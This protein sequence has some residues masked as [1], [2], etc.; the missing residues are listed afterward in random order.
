MTGELRVRADR[1]A[2]DEPDRGLPRL[3]EPSPW[4]LFF[5][6]EA[7]PWAT[8]V[9]LE[10]LLGI[11][12]EVDG[13]PHYLDIWATSQD[14]EKAAFERFIHLVIERLDAHPEMHV[15]HYGGYESGAIKRLMQRHQ[16][17]VD[18][19][20][21]LLRGEVLVDLLNVVRQ[22]VRAS[23]ESYSLKQIEKFYMPTREGPVTEAGFSVVAFETWLKNGDQRSSTGSRP[24]TAM[25]ASRP[26]CSGAGSRTGERRPSLAG[27]SVAGTGRPRP[28][29]APSDAV[30]DWLQAV[31]ERVAGLTEDLAPD[32]HHPLPRVGGC[33]PTSSIGIGARRSPVVALVRAEGRPDDRGARQRAR[34]PRR[35]HVRRPVRGR[36]RRLHRRYRFQ[37]QDHGFDPGDEAFATGTGKAAGTIVAIDDTAG[38]IELKRSRRSVWPHPAALMGPAPLQSI[39]QRQAMLRVADAVIAGGLDGEGAYRAIRDMLLRLAPRRVAGWGA[40][41]VEPGEDVLD[42]ARRLALELDAGTLPIQGPPGTGKTYA[43]ARMIL[44]LVGAGKRVGV[45]AQ[46]HKTISNIL[47]AVVEAATEEGAVVRIIQKADADTGHVEGVGRVGR[48]MPRSQPRLSAGTVDVVGGDRLA[49]R[50]ARVRRRLRRPVRGRGQPAV[51]GQCGRDGARPRARSCSSAIRTS[52]RWSPRGPP[53]GGGGLVPRA[54]RGRRGDDAARARPLPRHLASAAPGGQR[55]HLA[56]LLRRSPGDASERRTACR[57]RDTRSC[58]GRRRWLPTSHTAMARSTEEA[59]V[60]ARLVA[61]SRDDVAGPDGSHPAVHG[62]RHHH[63]RALQRAGR[64]DPG[65]PSAADRTRGNVGTVDKFQGREGAVAIY[66]MASSSREDAP[67]DMGFLY[68]GTASTSPYPGARASRSSSRHRRSLE[69]GCRTP[70]QMCLVDALCRFVE[71]AGQR[72]GRARRRAVPD[73]VHAPGAEEDQSRRIGRVMQVG[74]P[75]PLTPISVAG[76][77]WTS[78]PAAARAAAVRGLPSARMT[79]PG[80]TARTLQPSVGNSSSGTSTRRM[81]RSREELPQPDRQERQVDDGE[82]V[83]DRR[84]DRHEVD[85]LGRARASTGRRRPGRRH[86]R[87]RRAG[88]RPPRSSAAS[89]RCRTGPGGARACRRPRPCRA[90]R[91]GPS[92]GIP[93]ARVQ[94]SMAAGSGARLGLPGRSGIAPR[95]VTRSGSNV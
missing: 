79:T 83:G 18:E 31:E 36:G 34:R 64:G 41:L 11:V 59:E 61:T 4:D 93:A 45:T 3:P 84:D 67:R 16:T 20:D 14:E 90:P 56:G 55:V 24:T 7:D 91:S 13:Q 33:S 76:Y 37:P 46:S 73:G 2:P 78:Q 52:C 1:T 54:P 32:D 71:V 5:D 35:P 66:S 29:T 26:G 85:E 58:P 8:E 48:A 94:A 47:E 89:A 81:P 57:R 39:P 9:G 87:A 62:R 75:E 12:E 86:R 60:V 21:R 23:V 51:A 88:G 50:P 42:A 22:G 72:P 10:Y 15:Y 40:P 63:R 74:P 25:T 77:V 27:R 70:E 65:G 82:V 30:N 6:I 38:L 53:G 49:L 44:D 19:V 95:S 80:R 69:A 43:G 17:C 28:S 68:S 92:V